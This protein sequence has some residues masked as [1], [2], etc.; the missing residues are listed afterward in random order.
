MGVE[1]AHLASRKSKTPVAAL[2]TPASFLAALAG[3]PVLV[4]LPAFEQF[5]KG[6]E[7]YIDFTRVE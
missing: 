4:R 1:S 7:Y 3:T 5:E 6:A 2:M